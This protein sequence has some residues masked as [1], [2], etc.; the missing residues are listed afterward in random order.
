MP[1]SGDKHLYAGL[2][3]LHILHHAGEGPIYGQ[4]IM[5]ELGRHGYRLG[6]GTLY[7]ILHQ[8]E[9]LNWLRSARTVVDT[10]CR[11]VYRLTPIGRIVLSRARRKVHELFGELFANSRKTT[12]KRGTKTVRR[13][14]FK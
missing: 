7:P 10:R 11:R 12:S 1:R 4:W 13:N 8:M 3:R 14:S 5:D 9:R 6:P 2:I